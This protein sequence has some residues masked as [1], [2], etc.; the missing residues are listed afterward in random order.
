MFTIIISLFGT[1]VGSI[2]GVII[3]N[4]TK[5][6]LSIIT[7]A[8]AGIMLSIVVFDLIP[9]SINNMKSL[10]LLVF[11]II[12][13]LITLFINNFFVYENNYYKKVAA[14][15]ILGLA[16]HNFPEGL[17]M[18]SGV[19]AMTSMGLKM[20]IIITLHDIPEGIAAAAP[21]MASHEKISKI[22]F[23]SFLSAL[24]T[25]LGAFIG[26]YLGVVSKNIIGMLYSIVSGIMSYIV[27]AEMIPESYKLYNKI[28][29][30]L[31]V[32]LGIFIGIMII[33]LI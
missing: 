31:G 16:I 4:P 11:F 17:I 28:T 23:Y 19:A 14:L 9:Q 13:V 10:Y 18:G 6:I 5:K 27:C 24:P 15:V 26:L 30:F 3:R 12:G 25:L 29:C 32:F 8:A 33:F 20:S 7:G 1:V 2:I 22:M 21:M